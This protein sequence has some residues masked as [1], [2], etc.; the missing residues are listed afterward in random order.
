MKLVTKPKVKKQATTELNVH[1]NNG[2]VGMIDVPNDLVKGVQERISF[3]KDDYADKKDQEIVGIRNEM[4]KMERQLQSVIKQKKDDIDRLNVQLEKAKQIDP[5][6]AGTIQ[7]LKQEN[8][9]FKIVIGQKEKVIAE[10]QGQISAPAPVEPPK[11]PEAKSD[12]GKKADEP[13]DSGGK[14]SEAVPDKGT[15]GPDAGE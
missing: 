3:T 4:G 7:G 6:T 10:L 11:E 9:N 13:K 2:N 1:L 5:D 14:T 8:D 12:E 15:A